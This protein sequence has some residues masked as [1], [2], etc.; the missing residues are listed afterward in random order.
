MITKS[1]TSRR[2]PLRRRLLALAFA[3]VFPLALFGAIGLGFFIHDQ[4]RQTEQ[5]A[6]ESSR[7]AATTIEVE[8]SR[9]IT[10]LQALGESPL[11]DAPDLVG[12]SALVQRVLPVVPG[13]RAALVATPEGE[14][15][16]RVS[17]QMRPQHTSGPMAEAESFQEVIAT[18]KTVVGQLGRGPSG[19]LAMPVRLPIFRNGELKYVLTAVVSP[20]LIRDARDTR[21]L[22]TAWVGSVFDRN[23]MR[24]TR[25]A[26]HEESVGQKALPSLAALLDGPDDEGGGY[27]VTRE[28]RSVY[29]AFVRLPASGWTVTTAIPTSEFTGAAARALA[30]YGSGLALSLLLAFAVAVLA[31]RR[32]SR[33]MRDL[34]AAARN[35]GANAHPEPPVTDIEEIHDVGQALIDASESRRQ[36]ECERQ[37][38]LANL[39][40][41]RDELSQQV[42][43]LE[44]LQ[45]LNHRLLQLPSLHAQLQAILETVCRFHGSEFGHISLSRNGEPLRVFVSQGLSAETVNALGTIEPGEGACGKAISECRRVVI[46][47]TEVDPEFAPYVA[48]ARRE[49]FAAVHSTPLHSNMDGTIGA[50]TVQLPEAREP[51]IREQRLADMCASKAAVFI[52]RARMQDAALQSQQRLRVAL[53]SSVIPFGIA[54]AQGDPALPGTR[55]DWEYLNPVGV[56]TLTALGDEGH[57]GQRGGAHRRILELCRERLLL[58]EPSSAEIQGED[59]AGALRWLHIVATPFEHN[60]AVW[61][62]DVTDRK[63]QEQLL[64]DA[65]LQKDRFLAVLAHELRNPLAPIRQAAALI[66]SPLITEAKRMRACETIERNVSLMGALLDDLLDVSRVTFGKIQLRLVTVTAQDAVRAALESTQ[67]MRV[68]KNHR[69]AV[70]MPEEPLRVRADPLRLE[71]ILTNLFS[72]AARYTPQ[73]GSLKV[74]VQAAAGGIRIQVMDNGIGLSREDFDA[75]FAMFSQVDPRSEQSAGGLGIGL[76]LARALARQHGGDIEVESGGRGY[77]SQ[78]TLHLPLGEL[79][80]GEDALTPGV[81]LSSEA[82]GRRVLVVDDDAD[83]AHTMAELLELEG[84]TVMVALDGEAALAAFATYRPD[85]VLSDIGMP[86]LNGHQIARAIRAAEGGQAV[87]LIAMTGWGQADDQAEAYAA[88]F[89]HHVT[90]P[91]D[92]AL[93]YQLVAAE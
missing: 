91:A 41:A 82:T 35:I 65:D 90:K 45:R 83:I 46:A 64:R 28:G 72:N 7:Q 47:D 23:E 50:L 55:L 88:G 86:G 26:L 48:I 60:V 78:F 33:P 14:I 12:F 5:R 74:V 1:G 30:V 37:E 93:I 43:D 27:S 52:D 49:G 68:A 70:Q 6:L 62:T 32:V 54:T 36:R 13:W 80:P 51:T 84:H 16:R 66:T 92:I 29:V 9:T 20:E 87:R 19:T 2:V 22:P 67:S 79:D 39:S 8:L 53:E 57:G 18:G 34:Q 25:T 58:G 24:I 15:V 31:S 4:Q 73:D 10:V 76:A 85:V 69:L 44:V 81:G 63:H 61:F 59:P 21:T 3:G 11:L 89:D 40:A 42:V 77:G 75:V 38:Y 56:T 17:R 71:Q